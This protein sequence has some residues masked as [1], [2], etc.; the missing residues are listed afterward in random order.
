MQAS[1]G[2]YSNLLLLKNVL[3]RLFLFQTVYL[4]AQAMQ[5]MSLKSGLYKDYNKF[6][7]CRCFLKK[8]SKRTSSVSWLGRYF[9][10][11]HYDRQELKKTRQRD[12][13]PLKAPDI[14]GF[15]YQAK[16]LLPESDTTS[17][18]LLGSCCALLLLLLL[19]SPR[20]DAK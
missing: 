5:N 15:V 20:L 9:A 3:H 19:S 17:R 6:T 13:R 10:K 12:C 8:L 14:M 11:C 18:R 4:Y 1:H 16:I 2:T 7:K